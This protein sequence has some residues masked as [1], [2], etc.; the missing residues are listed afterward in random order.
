MSRRAAEAHFGGGD[1]GREF[2]RADEEDGE[3]EVGRL[4]PTGA[5]GDGRGSD[6][7]RRGGSELATMKLASEI[8]M[9]ESG[10]RRGESVTCCSQVKKVKRKTRKRA[11]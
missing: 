1:F 9:T 2:S 8:S 10:R 7:A 11:G 3:E 6:G 5:S 4:A